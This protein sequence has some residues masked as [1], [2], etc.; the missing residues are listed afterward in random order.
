M[1]SFCF[2]MCD[3]IIVPISS[4]KSETPVSETTCR[5]LPR[6]CT[7]VKYQERQKA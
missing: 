6:K 5:N 3:F 4:W 2:E 1:L 7:P